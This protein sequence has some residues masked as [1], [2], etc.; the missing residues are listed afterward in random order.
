MNS[1]QGIITLSIVPMR[2]EPSDASEMVSQGLFGESFTILERDEKWLKIRLHHD[3]YEG[4]ISNKQWMAVEPELLENCS[5]SLSLVAKAVINRQVN[6]IVA[7]SR[8]WN[9]KNEKGGWKGFRFKT[10]AKTT[11]IVSKSK[12]KKIIKLAESM[13]GAPYL[14]GGRSIFGIDCSGFTQLVFSLN[15][16]QLPRDAYQQATFGEDIQLEDAQT[17]DLAFFKNAEGRVTHT[18]IIIKEKKSVAKIIHASG[19]VR[20]DYLDEQGIFPES[21][22]EEKEYSHTLHSIRR[23]IG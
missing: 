20:T 11:D 13:L 23:V 21:S 5:L 2:K 4:W 17:G 10:K 16:C 9:F 22:G 7:G 12:P 8:L 3:G 6:L 15:G 1:N 14:W 18:G 19:C